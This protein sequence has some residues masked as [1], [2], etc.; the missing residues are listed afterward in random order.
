MSGKRLSDAEKAEIVR[1][2]GEGLSGSSIGY[3]VGRSP[4]T[5]RVFLR[6]E[7]F[8]IASAAEA[9]SGL[10]EEDRRSRDKR[11]ARRYRDGMTSGELSREFGLE[12]SSIN[13]ILEQQ[14]VARRPTWLSLAIKRQRLE[15]RPLPR[16]VSNRDLAEMVRLYKVE[17]ISAYEIASRLGRN[18]NQVRYFLVKAGVRMRSRDEVRALHLSRSQQEAA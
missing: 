2:H 9:S 1:L 12:D 10:S 4:S 15:G 13:R 5:V 14:G 3:L 18:M 11:I 7:G 8:R 17:Q 16:R 6:R